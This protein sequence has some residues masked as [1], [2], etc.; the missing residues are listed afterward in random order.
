MDKTDRR[1]LA[2]LESNARTSAAEIG[3]QIGLSRTAVQD[4][5]SKLEAD[6]VIAGYR[7][8]VSDAQDNLIRAML[9]VKIAVRPCDRALNW[10]ASLE[11]VR[12]VA[13]LSGDV[14][15]IVSCTVPDVGALT[16]LNDK[17]GASDL[18]TS[19]TSN[20]VLRVAR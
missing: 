8:Q 5:M 10:M 6:G 2:V 7:V 17:I 3:R 19:S 1:I 18:I 14:D 4:R 16:A 13:S 20:L 15:A 11:G 9:F 12:E